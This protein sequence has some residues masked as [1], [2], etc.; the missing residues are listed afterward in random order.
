MDV[1]SSQKF[2][3]AILPAPIVPALTSG[4][5]FGRHASGR[6]LLAATRV[7]A[8]LLL[9]L[10]GLVQPA[11]ADGS[12]WQ[13]LTGGK[14]DLFL[15]Y[16][17]EYADDAKPG[18][19]QAYASTLRSALGY[20]T[21]TFRDASLYF[22][23]QD[24]RIV[25]ND[26]LFNDGSSRISDRAVITDAESTEIQQYYLRYGGLPKTVL[27]LGR[28]EFTH[29][30]V[31]S[32]Q[33]FLGDVT[34]RQHYQSFDA[35]H[36]VSLAIPHTV[37]DYSYIWNVNRIFGEDNP[38]PDAADFRSNSH[39]LNLQYSGRSGLKLEGYTYL[40]EFTSPTARLFSTATAGLRA[41]GDRVIAPNLRFGYAGE[42]A[43]QR[44]YSNNPETISVNY[45]LAELGLS[46]SVGGIL[47]SVGLKYDYERLEGEG[48]VRAF[49]TP[50][51][52]NHA[53]QGF[54]D[55]FL[56]TPGDGIQDHFVTLSA[57]FPGFQISANY[58]RFLSD[59]DSYDYGY[60]WDM[61]AERSFGNHILAGLKW[62]DYRANQNTLNL[63]RNSATGQAF[64]LTRFW[65]YVQFSY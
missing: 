13:S 65:A 18:L 44:D 63:T 34:W 47:E 45:A 38:R 32:L 53:F 28:Q 29:R 2:Q 3:M 14:P 25:G 1:E 52:T 27:T 21:G 20:R 33:R 19:K 57:K 36:L 16:R 15:R 23:I 8:A 61:L 12:L 39:L 30:L 62:A 60:E 40:L 46:Y 37:L 26:R 64:D 9:A 5:R 17:F 51:G 11:R 35:A 41:Q 4:L 56:V 50:L 24:V 54:A 48:G 55:R 7:G 6:Q 10:C 49:Q 31:P 58:H 59:R 43:H 22:Q 42:F